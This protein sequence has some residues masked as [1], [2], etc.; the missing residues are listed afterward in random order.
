V[1]APVRLKT[2]RARTYRSPSQTSGSSP[3]VAAENTG[4][5]VAVTATRASIAGTGQPGHSPIASPGAARISKPVPITS[6]GGSR[7]ARAV[8][9]APPMACGAKPMLNA[10]AVKKA[11][12]V[13]A[14]TST[15][16]P[17]ISN[18]KPR[19][20]MSWAANSTRNSRTAN[21]E[22]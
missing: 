9:N 1:P 3:E 16:R 5:A 17:R 18:S 8:N 2:E 10:S 11:D 19:T 6:R 15:D 21:T 20:Y 7:S 12:R 4:A 14:Y 22:R 13:C